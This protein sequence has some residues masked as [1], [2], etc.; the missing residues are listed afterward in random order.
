MILYCDFLSAGFEIE[1]L[2]HK[3]FDLLK[4]IRCVKI[5]VLFDLET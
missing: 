3:V 5:E 4:L 2:S 1:R